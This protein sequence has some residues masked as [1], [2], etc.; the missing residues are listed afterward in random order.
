[1]WRLSARG[2]LK[3][4]QCNSA[5]H[6]PKNTHEG[7]ECCKESTAIITGTVKINQQV[8]KKAH[9]QDGKRAVNIKDSPEMRNNCFISRDHRI[10]HKVINLLPYLGTKQNLQKSHTHQH[11]G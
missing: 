11:A 5:C 6:I 1:M 10:P 8:H 7:K 2:K 9:N 3:V 4:V